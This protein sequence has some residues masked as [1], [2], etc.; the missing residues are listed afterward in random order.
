[1]KYFLTKFLKFT[2]N[3]GM[4]LIGAFIVFGSMPATTYRNTCFPLFITR[5][6]DV[7]R[8]FQE[9][10]FAEAVDS[11]AL[12]RVT[13]RKRPK[14]DIFS[15]LSLTDLAAISTSIG[16]PRK[17]HI[18]KLPTNKFLSPAFQLPLRV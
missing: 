17:I 4:P 6:N 2:L 16:N 5:L 10:T 15:P 13:I 11:T 9:P 12:E 14:T 3:L 18:D 7:T 8:S 1:M